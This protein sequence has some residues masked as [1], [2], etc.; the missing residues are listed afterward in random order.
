MN[1]LPHWVLTDKFPAF[2]DSDSKTAIEQTAR[3]YAAMQTLIAEC[4]SFVDSV[5]QHITDFENGAKKDYEVFTTELRQEFQ[6]FIDVIEL[7]IQSQDKKIS[8]TLSEQDEQISD[9]INY[10]KTNLRATITALIEQMRENGELTEDILA[11]FEDVTKRIETLESNSFVTPEM[12]G[13]AGDG[14]ADDTQSFQLA[15]DSDKRFLFLQNTY[16]ISTVSINKPKY[17]FG[18][19]I[20][21]ESEN[22]FTIENQNDITF[23]NVTMIL[24][25]ELHGGNNG[26]IHIESSENIRFL[27]CNIATKTYVG[28]KALNSDKCFVDKCIFESFGTSVYFKDTN[29]FITNNESRQTTEL[30]TE[31][32]DH[33]IDV[34]LTTSD[35]IHKVSICGNIIKSLCNAIQV[36]SFSE[37]PANASGITISNNT[38]ETI[39]TTRGVACKFD[40]IENGSFISN[41]VITC[42]IVISAIGKSGNTGNLNIL[43]NIIDDFKGVFIHGIGTHGTRY[44][45]GE[46]VV[47]NNKIKGSG[48]FC[49]PSA[50][51]ERTEEQKIFLYIENNYIEASTFYFSANTTIPNAEMIIRNNTVKTAGT[52]SLMPDKKLIFEN[53]VIDGGSL[54]SPNTLRMG[55]LFASV[56]NNTCIMYNPKCAGTCENLFVSNNTFKDLTGWHCPL[57]ILVDNGSVTN[58]YMNNF[59]KEE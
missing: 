23:D 39:T 28:I 11:A 1:L 46:F 5:N 59:T 2:Y 13:A 54:E 52:I 18:G 58:K 45:Y 43:D 55:G 40:G 36:T 15:L 7:K 17:I 29:G 24:G 53:N 48:E 21:S 3:V 20:V 4:N 25:S 38:I 30:P 42:G 16:K 9:A 57:V 49:Y 35:I 44:Q 27:N 47:K 56:Q 50:F 34:E 22:T 32:A 10:M 8:D 37:S 14:I 31:R 41:H 12:F 51:E 26:S 6:D 19:N 33:N